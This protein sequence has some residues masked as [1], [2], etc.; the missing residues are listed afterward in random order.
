MET[1]K[2]LNLSLFSSLI[3]T[4]L[5]ITSHAFSIREATINDLQLAFKQNQLTSR[6]LVQFYVGE[7]RRLNSVLNGLIEI[8][9]DALYQADKADYE[10]SVN[11]PGS[12][13]GLH[14]IPVL[15]KDNIGTK[16]R[17]N[18]TAG[19][20]GLFRSVVRRDAGVVMKLRKTGAIILG[21]ASMTE[22]AAF[23]S[24]KLP[25]GFSAR[26]GQGKNPYVLSA[27]PC[28][29]SSGPAISVAANLVAVSVGTETD[30]SILCPS[31]ANSVVGIKP[32]VG[33]TSR[34][35]VVPVSFRQDTVGPICRTVSDAVYVLDAIVGEDYNDGATKEASQHIPYGGYKQ[36][37]KPY[38]LKGKR[39]GV[40]R[41]PFLS[42]ASNAESQTFEYHLQTLRQGGAI[43]VDHLEIANINTIL[44]PNAS[45]EATA[46]LAE[47]KISLNAYLETLVASQVRSLAEVIK[48]NQEFADVEK[49]EEFGQDIF[50][51]AQATNGIGKAERAALLNLAKL[52]RDGFQKLMWDNKLD[53]LVTPGAGVAPVLAIGG[54]PG[55]NVPAGYD[56]AGVPFGINFGGLKGTEPKLIQIA[57]GFEQATKIRKPPTFKA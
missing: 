42:F 24:L 37:L 12:L 26:G 19:S 23:R 39:L 50:L 2:R 47:F 55:I 25:N 32:T 27:D 14:G 10:R 4:L 45:G 7:I 16:D 34:A 3:L 8:N 35:G 30:G 53:A 33:L 5:A 22:W 41:N 13:V 20:F 52:T 38:G 11:A 43:I 46:L 28:G 29:S 31:N 9:P 1:N 51:A 18:T 17:L 56:Y 21:K 44:N 48:F 54:F 6:K 40:V 57:Y 15:L 49:I 36:F